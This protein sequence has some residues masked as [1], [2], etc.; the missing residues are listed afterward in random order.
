MAVLA[1]CLYL[2][3]SM[4]LMINM[5]GYFLGHY[6]QHFT[7][8][9]DQRNLI[10]QTIMFFI[11]LAGGAGVF[12]KVCDW[13]FADSLYFCDV[14]ILTVGFGDFAA[15]NDVGRGLVFPYSVGGIIILGLMVGSIVRFVHELGE[16]MVVK[17]H[18]E[19]RRIRTVGRSI[20]LDDLTQ[21]Q[22]AQLPTDGKRPVISR[23]L[24]PHDEKPIQIL[25]ANDEKAKKSTGIIARIAYP[26]PVRRSVK[27]I[28]GRKSK[29]EKL[30]VMRE[31]RDRFEA[32]RRIQRE[33]A[34]FKKWY[35]L[36][37]SVIAFGLLW[38]CGAVVFWVAEQRIQQLTYFEA[39]YFCYVSL[40]TIGYGDFAPKSNAGKPFF[41]VW[42][43]IAVP[44]MTVLIS[45]LGDTVIDDFKKGTFKL[46]DWTVLPKQGIYT[47]FVQRNRL[48]QNWRTKREERKRI[49]AGFPTGA[50]DTVI[51]SSSSALDTDT[52]LEKNPSRPHTRSTTNRPM[53]SSSIPSTDGALG[54]RPGKP[55]RTL[56]ALA[57]E[58]TSLT[59]YDLALRLAQT[60]S[61]MNAEARK[62]TSHDPYTY[63]QWVEF[64]R[65]IR[66]S[67]LT[68]QRERRRKAQ[69]QN[70][71]DEVA[72]EESESG[73]VDW[74]WIGEDSPMVSE[75][76]E[77]EWVLDR[78]LESLVRWT[79]QERD[80]Q[81][82]IMRRRVA[83]ERERGITGAGIEGSAGAMRQRGMSWCLSD[84]RRG[85]RESEDLIDS[86]HRIDTE[87]GPAIDDGDI[88]AAEERFGAGN[89]EQERL[90]LQRKKTEEGISQ[91]VAATLTRTETARE[92]AESNRG[93]SGPGHVDF[94]EP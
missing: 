12:S 18:V 42:S 68:R 46:A 44:T 39:L 21:D 33:S 16:D 26:K 4:I 50:E 53:T 55:P 60:L 23:P 1:A 77:T 82:V 30:L 9:D 36:T 89:E 22:I 32:M 10:L 80:R 19:K 49:A 52:D 31:E 78:L 83:R 51:P 5:L 17:Q 69:G 58:S 35:A 91:A 72:E 47:A 8:T 67:S 61:Q 14:T 2:F 37:M 43:L 56:E 79:K 66:F 81:R 62:S 48:L 54:S 13:S 6:P 41:I 86:Q 85:R 40:L 7:L 3:S 24:P 29:H 65:L 75:K 74:D 25:G 71:D 27:R 93:G 94:A 38:C 57:E 20:T 15:P 34:S 88:D 45:D 63:E 73:V 76:S 64:T 84:A 87:G 59:P 11:W 90:G 70:D 28:T 92:R